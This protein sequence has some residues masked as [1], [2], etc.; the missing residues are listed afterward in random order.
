MCGWAVGLGLKKGIQI[1]QTRDQRHTKIEVNNEHYQLNI[2]QGAK[3]FGVTNEAREGA[4]TEQ[5]KRIKVM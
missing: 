4:K 2:L 5:K 1:W 3:R